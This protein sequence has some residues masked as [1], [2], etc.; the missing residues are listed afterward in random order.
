MVVSD[1][2]IKGKLS[3]RHMETTSLQLLSKS[4]IIS[5]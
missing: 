5:K 1:V 2:N 4:K 3:E